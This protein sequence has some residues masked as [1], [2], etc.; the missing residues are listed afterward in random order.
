[1]AG[2]T[3]LPSWTRKPSA[4]LEQEDLDRLHRCKKRLLSG[5]NWGKENSSGTRWSGTVRLAISE[6]AGIPVDV[7][8]EL[9]VTWVVGE[10]FC[11][12]LFVIETNQA[13]RMYHNR[14]GHSAEPPEKLEGP[15]KHSNAD[16]LMRAQSI[17]PEEID[18]EEINAA[19]RG[20]FTEESISGVEVIPKLEPKVLRQSAIDEFAGYGP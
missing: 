8:L 15:H 4:L 20:F 19:L 2:R 9:E 16:R 12:R 7:H 13:V 5:F 10:K 14:P 18:P 6:D 11:F 1:M 17:P 3:T